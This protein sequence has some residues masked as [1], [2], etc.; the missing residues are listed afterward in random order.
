MNQNATVAAI[1]QALT[2]EM[3]DARPLLG[4]LDRLNS[5]AIES[6][7]WEISE[8]E[9]SLS[10][11][12]YPASNNGFPLYFFYRNM[13]STGMRKHAYVQLSYGGFNVIG[14]KGQYTIFR[15]EADEIGAC[16]VAMLGAKTIQKDHYIDEMLYRQDLIFDYQLNGQH[17]HEVFTKVLKRKPL[18]RSYHRTEEKEIVPIITK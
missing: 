8:K 10:V 11:S 14:E 1:K 16:I 18:F 7:T 13:E 17:K 2:K 3:K 5:K 6:I 4:F 12:I 9:G 15:D